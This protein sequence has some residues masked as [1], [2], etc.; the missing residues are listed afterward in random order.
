MNRS[1]WCPLVSH[2]F[3]NDKLL[4]KCKENDCAWWDSKE[5]DCIVFSIKKKL[6]EIKETI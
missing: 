4:T 2:E 1:G 5:R 3:E 6:D